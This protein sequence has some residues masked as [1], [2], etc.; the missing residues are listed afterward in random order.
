MKL[1]PIEEEIINLIRQGADVEMFMPNV[2]SDAEA[3]QCLQPIS[4][5][6]NKD[7]KHVETDSKIVS[8]YWRVDGV[9]GAGKYGWLTVANFLK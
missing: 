3:Q 9:M 1:T 7:V 8:A 6:L 2:S 5:L 4:A